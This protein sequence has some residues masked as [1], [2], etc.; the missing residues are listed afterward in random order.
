MTL[1]EINLHALRFTEYSDPD[2]VPFERNIELASAISAATQEFFQ[3][4]PNR[5][6][7]TKVSETIAAPRTISDAFVM[8]PDATRTTSGKPFYDSER[9]K[10][11]VLEGDPKINEILDDRTV[12][13]AYQSSAGNSTAGTVYHDT[14]TF[15]DFGVESAKTNLWM[16][17]GN[18]K[19]E[20]RH[21]EQERSPHRGG[22]RRSYEG[23]LHAG[24]AHSGRLTRGFGAPVG[25]AVEYVGGSQ[26]A[27]N[28]A[29]FMVRLDPIPTIS[30]VLTFEIDQLSRV[31]RPAD[32]KTTTVHP[33]SDERIH[34]MFL[35]LL[36]ERILATSLG[37]KI[38]ARVEKRIEKDAQMARG[39]I[40]TI[41]R[42]VVR[43]ER[44]LRQKRGF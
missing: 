3:L 37:T 36:Q 27:A 17:E 2:Q 6:K 4:A 35:P 33:V 15:F 21:I 13:M 34:A 40:Q 26:S 16:I 29:T 12:L 5:L 19:R 28:D 39:L 30:C 20:L 43:E 14:I 18:S 44:V 41:P 42:S 9:G 10:A 22:S 38:E 23:H 25:Y 11:V 7:K 32:L 1:S 24:S 31:Y 8:E